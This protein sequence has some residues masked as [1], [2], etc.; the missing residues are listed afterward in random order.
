MAIDKRFA[1][2]LEL[3]DM[4][5]NQFAES[6]GFSGSS[7]SKIILGKST[8]AYKMLIAIFKRYPQISVKWL[9]LGEGEPLETAENNRINEENDQKELQEELSRLSRELLRIKDIQEKLE[10]RVDDLE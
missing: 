6:I 9:I 2:L 7:I 10:K 8:P 5:G 1:S 4:S 3:L